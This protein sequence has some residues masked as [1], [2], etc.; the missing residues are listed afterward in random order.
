MFLVL[1][2]GVV[3]WILESSRVRSYEICELGTGEDTV[4][5]NFVMFTPQKKVR[6]DWSL[7]PRRRD[8]QNNGSGSGSHSN[9]ISDPTGVR[10][11]RKGVAFLDGT[12]T[13]EPLP[14]FD[15]GTEKLLKLE[16]EL[17]EYQYNMGLLLLEK[18]EWNSKYEELE[19][20]L[21]EAKDDLRSEQVTHSSAISV[22]EEREEKLRKALGVEKQCVLDLEKALRDLRSNNAETKFTSDSKLAEANALFASIEQKS[23][24]VEAKLNAVDAKLAEVSGRTAEAEQKMKEME[25]LENELRREQLTLNAEREANKVLLSEQREDLLQWE[26]RLKEGEERL[27]EV[28]R[29]LKQREERGNENDKIFMKKEKEFHEA[30]KK[31]D[32]TNIAL[33][34]KG[35][36][37]NIRLA[38]LTL[39][40]KEADIIKKNLEMKEKELLSLE[41]KLTARETVEIKKLVDEHTAIL[42]AKKC[43]FELEI[44]QKRK[45]VDEDLKSKVDE[46]GKKE[47]EINHLAEKVARHGQAL[48]KKQEKLKEKEKEFDSKLEA[49]KE[50]EESIRVEKDSLE[51]ERKKIFMEKEDLVDLKAGIDKMR[52]DVEE[53]Q[54]K[55]HV[56]KDQ[57]KVTEEER[58]EFAHLQSELKKEINNWRLQKEMLLKE[59][60]D[61]KQDRESFEREWEDLDEK[62]AEMQKELENINEEQRKLEKMKRSEEESLNAKKMATQDY[63]QRELD[64]LKFAKESFAASMEHEKSVMA[65]K[66]QSERSQLLNDFE[67]QKRELETGLQIKQEEMEKHLHESEKLF[68]EQKDKELKN[69]N[70]LSEVARREMEEMKLQRDRLEKDMQ[71]A[72]ANKILLE[73]QQH[74]IQKDI[75]E[76]LLLSGKLKA[77]RE[78]FIKEREHFVAFVEKH[79]NCQNCGEVTCEFMLSGLPSLDEIEKAEN[80][81]LPR[82][83]DYNLRE[84]AEGHLAAFERHQNE[85]SGGLGSGSGGTI[86]W[87][88]KCTTKIFNLSPSKK[89]EP[90]ALENPTYEAPLSVKHTNVMESS[91]ELESTESVPELSLGISGESFDIQRIQCDKN[92]QALETSQNLSIHDQSNTSKG[93]E[94]MDDCTHPKVKAGRGRPV[95]RSNPRVN[96]NKSLKVAVEDSKAISGKEVEESKT[97]QPN[98]NAQGS[99]HETAE[100]VR[101]S[102]FLNRGASKNGR[103]RNNA[104]ASQSMLSDDASSERHSD[105]VYECHTR[106]RRKT[107]GPSLQTPGAK[108]YNLRPKNARTSVGRR[109]LFDT[110]EENVGTNGERPGKEIPEPRAAAPSGGGIENKRELIKTGAFTQDGNAETVTRAVENTV[111]SEEVSCSIGG[112]GDSGHIGEIGSESPQGDRARDEDDDDDDDEIEHPGEV[113]IGKKLWTFLT[114]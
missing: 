30:Q 55:L 19:Q 39:K 78:R 60:E 112:T 64:A 40:E 111:L 51:I 110:N 82:M 49:Q 17:F 113:S 29:I 81:S 69:I 9:L 38:D 2:A 92:V 8:P 103:K 54:R 24:D 99:T 23:L 65:E 73:G 114:T 94:V 12:D 13:P 86:S 71:E 101:E 63:V 68:E 85:R 34:E 104:Y 74:D 4:W 91:K 79:K 20:K 44:D 72:T 98:G 14:L 58:L 15:Q 50:R 36:D 26:R 59:S 43:E 32:L 48:E 52:A 88:R 83:G 10:D 16:I 100:N 102:S 57:L 6:S 56:E 93:P 62:R 97:E 53:Q 28:R 84:G 95:K 61:L 45:S 21:A 77:Q 105:G 96:R 22:V 33:M 87:L 106:K 66:A 80:F 67:L 42:Q 47:T 89:F 5:D 70:N 108:R 25:I 31:I 3:V 46:L 11:G 35:E 1:S 41:E 18:K 107:V 37:I 75:N 7:S 76:L 109:A 90:L 27:V